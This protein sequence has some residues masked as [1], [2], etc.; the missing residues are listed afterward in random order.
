MV[1][2]APELARLGMQLADGIEVALPGW[3]E[4]AVERL[5]VAWAGAADPG[6]MVEARA[7]GVRARDEVGPEVRR[8]LTLDADRQRAN[9]LSLLRG[10]VRFPTEVLH[11][12]GVPAVVRDEFRERTF[13]ADIYD[14]A[15]A[16]FADI[17]PALHEPA[18]AWGAAK[19]YVILSRRKITGPG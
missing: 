9:P 4:R 6:A 16:G 14:L 5:L 12:A 11:R 13:P 19:A 10:A 2:A 8:L 18:L 7:A 3:V 15:P 1:D 17:D